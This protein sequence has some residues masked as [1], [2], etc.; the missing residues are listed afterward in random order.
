MKTKINNF[1]Q[2]GIFADNSLI[3]ISCNSLNGRISDEYLP[4]GIWLLVDQAG[5]D[6]IG[7]SK[8]R[9]NCIFETNYAVIIQGVQNDTVDVTQNIFTNNFM[10][11]YHEIGLYVIGHGM[12]SGP[13]NSFVSNNN[14]NGYST[15]IHTSNANVRS[16]YDYGIKATESN[17][18]YGVQIDSLDILHSTA[19]CGTQISDY[20]GNAGNEAQMTNTFTLCLPVELDSNNVYEGWSEG[21][22]E[23]KT[24]VTQNLSG[25]SNAEADQE[26]NFLLGVTTLNNNPIKFNEAY[27]LLN[28]LTN[29]SDFGRTALQL[30][31]AIHQKDFLL[32]KNLLSSFNPT[33]LELQEWKLVHQRLVNHLIEPVSY[34]EIEAWDQTALQLER[35]VLI[36]QYYIHALHQTRPLAIAQ[37]PILAKA[38]KGI[39]TVLSNEPQIAVYPNPVGEELNLLINCKDQ[40]PL[41]IQINN[42]T[43]ELVYQQSSMVSSG[44]LK[45]NLASLNPGLYLVNLSDAEG[46]MKAVKFVKQ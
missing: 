26:A 11:N 28:P 24:Q 18:G 5:F 27:A 39:R 37:I 12:Q 21:R 36:Q 17:F 20:P 30:K 6:Y 41:L 3:N 7:N 9:S 38:E 4:N 29:L 2:N 32:A 33:N 14:G 15:D 16:I 8:I 44:I 13:G 40:N 23:L 35:S 42:I 1:V 25:L 31:N 45:I 19:S 43:G 34:S 22:F 46:N 10:Y